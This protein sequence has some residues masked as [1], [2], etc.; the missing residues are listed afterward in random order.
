MKR[1]LPKLLRPSR[2]A[3]PLPDSVPV[4]AALVP[5]SVRH[6]PRARRL[7]LRIAPGGDRLVV[8]AP[9]RTTTATILAFLERHQD[10][11]AERLGRIGSRT[12]VE[13]GA[14]IPFRGRSL[15]ILHEPGQRAARFEEAGE[16]LRLVVG[17][18]AA[19]LKRRVADVLKREARRDLQAAVDRHAEA[20]GLKPAAMTLKDTRS[21]WGS[22]TH[23]R[24]LAFS[25]RIIMAPPEVLDYL[26]AHEVAHFRH[27]DH[28][29]GFWALC[30]TL[31][32]AMD[33]G[34]AWLKTHGASLH[35]VAFD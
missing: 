16:T 13:P 6:N 12:V 15:L 23:D 21:R 20:V 29:A 22:C 34:R 28:G 27:M 32:P 26:A 9:P 14:T 8:T 24:R 1:L 30:R 5:L 17:G 4:G 25:W 3:V 19:H 10:W 2:P 18:E 11:A 35:A 31:C 33:E 7:V